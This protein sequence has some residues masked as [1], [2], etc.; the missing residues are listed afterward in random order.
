MGSKIY[1]LNMI[2]ASECFGALFIFT[3]P[4]LIGLLQQKVVLLTKCGGTKTGQEIYK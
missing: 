3:L 1:Q 2:F 4:L